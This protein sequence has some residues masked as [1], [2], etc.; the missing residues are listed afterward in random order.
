[1]LDLIRTVLEQASDHVPLVLACVL[2]FA[3][4]DAAFGV[5]A[6]LPGETG[7]VLAAIALSDRFE[8][9]ALAVVTAALG[10]F[11]GDHLGFAVGR[12]FGSRLGDSK[13][14][15]RLGPDRWDKAREQVSGRFWAVIVAR[16]FPGIRTFVAAAAG[17]STMRYPRFATACAIAAVLWATLWVVGGATVGSGLLDVAERFTLP[18]LAALALLVVGRLFVRRREVTHS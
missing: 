6:V 17:A 15:R 18:T 3:V 10:A 1:M 2:V 16:L 14:V 9:V 13:L 8:H 7:I 5:G 4:I 12:R 11:I